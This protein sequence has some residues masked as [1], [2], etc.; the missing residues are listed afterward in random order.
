MQADLHGARPML[1]GLRGQSL[2]LLS[3]GG[4]EKIGAAV[5]P[6]RKGGGSAKGGGGAAKREGAAGA[7]AG[8]QNGAA[9]LAKASTHGEHPATQAAP[10]SSRVTGM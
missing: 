3:G 2:V 5:P 8:V 10:C 1:S 4:G 7:T 9:R 6:L